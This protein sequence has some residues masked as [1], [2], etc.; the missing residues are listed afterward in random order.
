MMSESNMS[1]FFGLFFLLVFATA[2]NLW[3]Q[4]TTPADPCREAVGIV[5]LKVE[6]LANGKVGTVTP[7]STLPFGLTD[8]A[9][10]AARQIKFEPKRENGVPQNSTVVFEYTYSFVFDEGSLDLLSEAVILSIP[11]PKI[12]ARKSA[13]LSD[14][15]QVSV[16]LNRDHDPDVIKFITPIPRELQD[17]IKDA[18]SKIK[19]KPAIHKCGAP[20][21][22]V[23]TVRLRIR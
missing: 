15:V 5:R 12:S 10:A 8:Q 21:T 6:L 3:G 1:R 22:E 19:F 20:V 2:S 4:Q 13:G 14:E 18:V 16:S 9:V 23:T 11:K 17:P 7:L